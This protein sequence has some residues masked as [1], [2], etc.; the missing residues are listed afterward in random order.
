MKYISSIGKVIAKIF[1]LAITT[2]LTQVGGIVLLIWW[3][4]WPGIRK[5]I[6]DSRKRGWIGISAFAGWW[7]I[8]SL[9]I[10]P[11]IAKPFGRV[12]LPVWGEHLRPL[13]IGTCLLN[14]H[15]VRPEL[16]ALMLESGEYMEENYPGTI[17]AYMDANFPFWNG[18]PLLP[19]L[20]HSDGKKADIAFFY[21]DAENGEVRHRTSH[22][23]MGY[24]GCETARKGDP[25]Y[26]Q[27]CAD[28]G[29]WQYSL[30]CRY[31]PEWGN[32][33]L[34]EGRTKAYLRF[35]ARNSQTGKILLEPHLEHRLGLTNYNKIRFHGCHAVRHDDHLHLQL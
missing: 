27:I 3:L 1:L 18:Y 15:Y 17:V 30:M 11:L 4:I 10:I 8:C 20:S 21:Q 28:R 9:I 19:H 29:H 23:F 34:D 16:K 25:D 26:G 14:R 12:P 31:I 2:L 6:A 22:T 7:C 33:K 13:N 32:L 35:L 24:G 5:R